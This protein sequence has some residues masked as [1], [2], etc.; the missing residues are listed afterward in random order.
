MHLDIITCDMSLLVRTCFFATAALTFALNSF[1]APAC[2]PDNGGL[3][4][5]AGFC[6]FLATTDGVGLARH[7]AV[8]PNGDVY[9]AIQGRRNTGGGVVALRPDNSGHFTTKEAFGTGNSTG[10]GLRK[11]DT[12][13]RDM[14]NTALAA[15][16]ADG[17]IKRL[18]LQWF[19]TDISPP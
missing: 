13:L 5:P 12:D 11:S 9:V 18:S 2:D 6:A 4:L 8:A 3:K 16:K 17:T 15:A 7:I 14:L 10:I 19:K 1:A